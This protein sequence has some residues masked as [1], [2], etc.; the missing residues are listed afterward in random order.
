MT[1]VFSI[2]F[3]LIFLRVLVPILK[4]ANNQKDTTNSAAFRK[5]RQAQNNFSS[6]NTYYTQ[7]RPS[8][9]EKDANLHKMEDRSSDW[10]AKQLRAEQQ[11]Q[12]VVSDMF[13]LKQEHLSH[14]AADTLR[15]EHF[16]NCDAR[17]VRI[18]EQARQSN[19][20]MSQMEMDALK[21]RIKQRKEQ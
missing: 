20:K 15:E 5:A 3:W 9:K 10:L 13:Q 6:N 18:E 1:V 17:Q 21:E 7:N 2:V 19:Q 8:T 12:I 14:C 16:S 11:A 4:K